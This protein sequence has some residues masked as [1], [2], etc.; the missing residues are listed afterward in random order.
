M[1]WLSLMDC[2]AFLVYVN[3]MLFV[4]IKDIKALLNRVLS[5]FLACLALWSLSNMFTHAALYS[6]DAALLFSRSGSFGWCSFAS[7]YLWFI[8]ILTRK[9]KILKSRIFYA[10][11]IGL[12]LV[13]ICI[14]WTSAPIVGLSL[15]PWGWGIVLSNTVPTYLFLLYYSSF[16]LAGIYFIYD[17]SRKTEDPVKKKQA[18]IILISSICCLIFP[19]ITDIIL[20]ELHIYVIPNIGTEILLVLTLAIVYAIARYKLLTVTPATAAENIIS[21]MANSLILL[22]KEGNILRVNKSTSDLLGYKENELE[23]RCAD[24]LSG[25]KGFKDILLSSAVKNEVIKNREFNFKKKDGES[26]PMI[27]SSSVMIDEAKN[28]AGIV[29]IAKDITGLKNAGEMLRM[30]EEKFR[31]IFN[32]ATDI[33]GLIDLN[34]TIVD[35]NDII[36]SVYGY[37]RENIIGKRI[38]DLTEIFPAKTLLILATNFKETITGKNIGSYVVEAKNKAGQPV[39]FEVNRVLRKDASGNFAGILVVMHDVTDHKKMEE[40]LKEKLVELENFQDLA[41]DRELKM[42]E[43]KEKIDELQKKLAKKTNENTDAKKEAAK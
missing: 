28:V 39:F 4:L 17:F 12:P 20:P 3:T 1:S 11:L 33:L 6:H 5:A 22:D 27:L 13:F 36:S 38:F 30:S 15:Q 32:A 10:A 41:V 18:Q 25:E 24:I 35:I 7:F 43:L 16:V 40:E 34:G 14:D 42:V 29:C 2:F 9:E 21:T 37:K 23:G 8:L 26:V 19:S 31:F